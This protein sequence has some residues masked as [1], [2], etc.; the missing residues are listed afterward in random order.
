MS[1]LD[2][3]RIR[4]QAYALWEAEGRPSG[5][6][7]RHWNEA[8]IAAVL[9]S[10]T[11]EVA[12]DPA[13]REAGTLSDDDDV[14]ADVSSTPMSD[15]VVV[16]SL[17]GDRETVDGLDELDEAVRQQSEDKAPGTTEDFQP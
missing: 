10:P 2:Q 13:D 15:R 11:G 6:A 8:E 9:E 5:S 16:D 12:G 7:D 14:H 4:R 1:D 3:E 17:S